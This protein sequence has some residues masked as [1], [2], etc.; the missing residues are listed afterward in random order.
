MNIEITKQFMKKYENLLNIVSV[1]DFINST[2]EEKEIYMNI[3][4][5]GLLSIKN[6][7]EENFEK[8]KNHLSLEK[9]REI[10]ENCNDNGEIYLRDINLIAALSK[11]PVC[12]KY[13]LLISDLLDVAGNKQSLTSELHDEN[14]KTLFEIITSNNSGSLKESQSFAILMSATKGKIYK[15]ETGYDYPATYLEDLDTI[16]KTTNED[17]AYAIGNIMVTETKN[18]YRA[19]SKYIEEI[20]KLDNLDLIEILEAMA[21]NYYAINSYYY[22]TNLEYVINSENLDELVGIIATNE[23]SLES[24]YHL[25]NLS[26]LDRIRYM[27]KESIIDTLTNIESLE[28][29]SHMINVEEKIESYGKDSKTLKKVMN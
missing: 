2:D 8:L 29:G 20:S 12:Q 11:L 14:M 25:Y 27:D 24:K 21:T 19:R 3:D 6:T 10:K 16:K 7:T 1:E 15:T 26:M 18:N 23:D 13:K 22:G 5:E 17:S 9:I 4:V 28:S